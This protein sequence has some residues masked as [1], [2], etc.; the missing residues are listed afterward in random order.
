MIYKMTRDMKTFIALLL[1]LLISYG[2]CAQILLEP[3]VDLAQQTIA[4]IFYR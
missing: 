4:N 3:N 2:I 1:L